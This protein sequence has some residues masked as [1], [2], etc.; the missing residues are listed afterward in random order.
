MFLSLDLSLCVVVVFVTIIVITL[1]VRDSHR[2]LITLCDS[3]CV[4]A[5]LF[6]GS[7]ALPMLGARS[8][9]R[10]FNTSPWFS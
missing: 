1:W 9:G 4:V 2:D 5:G 10:K 7:L 8:Q 3:L 6:I